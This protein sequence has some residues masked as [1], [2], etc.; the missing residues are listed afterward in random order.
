M[1]ISIITS[2]LHWYHIISP[3]IANRQQTTETSALNTPLSNPLNNLPLNNSPTSQHHLVNTPSTL[4]QHPVNTPS[5]RKYTSEYRFVFCIAL[6]LA[7][8]LHCLCIHCTVAINIWTS[9][10][11]LLFSNFHSVTKEKVLASSVQV[12]FYNMYLVS[13]ISSSQRLCFNGGTYNANPFAT[14]VFHQIMEHCFDQILIYPPPTTM[15][16]LTLTPSTPNAPIPSSRVCPHSYPTIAHMQTP[17]RLSATWVES[18]L[19]LSNS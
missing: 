11:K 19:K 17:S 13:R 4:R 15:L 14:N 18:T 12:N 10:Y 2:S 3:N 9:I 16:H 6:C 7:M 5:T 1:L 8:S